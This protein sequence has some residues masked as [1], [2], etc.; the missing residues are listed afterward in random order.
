MKKPQIMKTVSKTYWV[1]TM[2]LNALHIIL[3]NILNNGYCCHPQFTG[4]KTHRR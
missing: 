4:R 1:L 2:C 3:C